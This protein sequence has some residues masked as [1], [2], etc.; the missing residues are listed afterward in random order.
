LPEPTETTVDTPPVEGAETPP[1]DIDADLPEGQET[2]D[3]PY[4]EK[5]RQEAAAKRVAAKRFEPLSFLPDDDL[6]GLAA[7][8]AGLYSDDPEVQKQAAQVF[9]EVGQ[10]ALGTPQEENNPVETPQPNENEP[11]LSTP[12]GVKAFVAAQ[13]KAEREAI[14]QESEKSQQ[15]RDFDAKAEGLG[16]KKGTPEH[17]AFLKFAVDANGDP[18][19][20]DQA[21]KSWK[22]TMIDEA[23]EALKNDANNGTTPPT[24]T[25]AGTKVTKPPES[26]A[27]ATKA[28]DALLAAQH[29]Q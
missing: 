10:Q 22:Q 27:A 23:I 1:I 8:V 6:T 11:D 4:V 28:L 25:G 26:L 2:F 9:I 15:Q 24:G 21:F 29:Q 13:L 12:E 18:E 16:Y 19:K 3:R 14:Q 5:L 17:V 20:A 7:M